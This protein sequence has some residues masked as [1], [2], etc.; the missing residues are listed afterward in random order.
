MQCYVMLDEGLLRRLYERTVAARF[1]YMEV[2]PFAIAEQ[3]SLGPKLLII[4][5]MLNERAFELCSTVLM[6]PTS[7]SMLCYTRVS[8]D[9]MR[10]LVTLARFGFF[11]FILFDHDD[12]SERLHAALADEESQSM[13]RQLLCLLAPQVGQLNENLGRVVSD[14]FRRTCRYRAARDLAVSAGISQASMYRAFRTVG[15]CSP[16]RLITA[17]RVARVACDAVHGRQ[18][19]IAASKGAGYCD[20]RVLRSELRLTL[21]CTL[22]SLRS[23]AETD[24][25]DELADFA[26]VSRRRVPGKQDDIPRE[27]VAV[28]AL[29]QNEHCR[30]LRREKSVVE[31][32][33][34]NGSEVSP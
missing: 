22:Q 34:D 27:Q 10:G 8:A 13:S 21:G 32:N 14:L 19:L 28:A 30:T 12:T 3:R 2:E 26:T 29:R 18:S 15:L 31:R 1:R 24:V 9:A 16:K 20:A 4:D 33:Q 11:R 6:R 7:W 5:P 25:V 23:Y 17:A